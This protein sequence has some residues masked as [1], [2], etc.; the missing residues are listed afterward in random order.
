VRSWVRGAVTREFP[1]ERDAEI[2]GVS[3]LDLE[4]AT[5]WIASTPR[6]ASTVRQGLYQGIEATAASSLVNAVHLLV[7]AIGKPGAGPLLMA[8]MPQCAT[9]R[10]ARAALTWAIAIPTVKR[11]CANCASLES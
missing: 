8:V 4:T 11:R 10:R 3:R 9:G 6:M 2:C 1:P 5:E 7:V